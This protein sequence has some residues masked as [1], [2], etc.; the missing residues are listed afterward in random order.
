MAHLL[1]IKKQTNY[2]PEELMNGIRSYYPQITLICFHCIM[3][4]YLKEKSHHVFSFPSLWAYIYRTGPILAFGAQIY[5]AYIALA[6]ANQP[7][8]G[9]LIG[10]G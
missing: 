8:D 9:T 5:G 7:R 1:L 3:A 6:L 10:A 4:L 2:T